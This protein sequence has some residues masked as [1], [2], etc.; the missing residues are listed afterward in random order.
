MTPRVHLVIAGGHHQYLNYLAEHGLSPAEY[1]P[2]DE[3]KTRGFRAEQVASFDQVGTY[4]E[5]PGWGG[6]DYRELMEAG[7]ALDKHWA[8]PWEA[9]FLKAQTLRQSRPLRPD[10]IAKAAERQADLERRFAG[11]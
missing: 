1:R 10:D 4:W 7:M 11:N 3:M 5:H 6:V 2:F 9:D 8:L